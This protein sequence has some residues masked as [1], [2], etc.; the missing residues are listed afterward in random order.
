MTKLSR[1]VN[2]P[3][4][5]PSQLCNLSLLGRFAGREMQSVVITGQAVAA[6]LSAISAQSQMRGPLPRSAARKG[7]VG[8]HGTSAKPTC[9][10]RRVKASGVPK[11]P[12]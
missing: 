4:E 11:N 1:L 9:V 10:E 8:K 5:L 7:S 6:R 12:T 2:Q 3:V